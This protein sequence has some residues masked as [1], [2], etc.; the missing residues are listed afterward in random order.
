MTSSVKI[1]VDPWY[2]EAEE[3]IVHQDCQKENGNF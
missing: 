3:G 1:N 2:L